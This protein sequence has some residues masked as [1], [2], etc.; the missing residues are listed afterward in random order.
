MIRT[1]RRAGRVGVVRGLAVAVLVVAVGMVGACSV[2]TPVIST[3]VGPSTTIDRSPSVGPATPFTSA[4]SA[5]IVTPTT[6]AASS[7]PPPIASAKDFDQ[8]LQA[9]QVPDSAHALTVSGQGAAAVQ[10]TL[11]GEFAVVATLDAERCRGEVVL[12][13][14]GRMT[15]YAAGTAPYRASVLVDVMAGDREILLVTADGPWTLTLLDWNYL[16]LVDGVQTGRGPTVL[17]FAS[18]ATTMEVSVSDIAPT[19][20]VMLRAFSEE[21]VTG[22]PVMQ[23]WDGPGMHT[24]K[25]NLP[26]VV[27]LRTNGSWTMTPKP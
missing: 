21:G 9:G 27:A 25:A 22:G 20:T 23:S 26:G 16:P 24:A 14:D 17:Y 3:P 18:A 19:D 4:S 12:T 2:P 13:A 11:A 15:P 1:N 5:P 10:F 8:V 6:V 7:S